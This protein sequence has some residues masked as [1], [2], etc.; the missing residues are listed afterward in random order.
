MKYPSVQR[1]I[2]ISL[3]FFLPRFSL[4]G[5]LA[6]LSARPVPC[7]YVCMYVNFGRKL[8]KVSLGDNVVHTYPGTVKLVKVNTDQAPGSTTN[9]S[10]TRA[11]RRALW[12]QGRMAAV[13]TRLRSF[14]FRAGA[15]SF[16]TELAAL[17]RAKEDQRKRPSISCNGISPP[18]TIG[19]SASRAHEGP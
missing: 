11:P 14:G 10:L 15:L 12:E 7:Y 2:K 19:L 13:A 9:S 17:H 4:G 18:L 16:S 1:L 6:G 8:F 5:F 3:A